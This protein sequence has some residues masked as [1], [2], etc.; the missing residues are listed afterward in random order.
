ML[1]RER[2]LIPL[3]IFLGLAVPLLVTSWYA[4]DLQRKSIVDLLEFSIDQK[5]DVLANGLKIPMWTLAP[6]AGS[7]LV[8]S[9]IDDPIIHSIEATSVAEGPFLSAKDETS[10]S[11]KDSQLV[12]RDVI[13][14]AEKIGEVAVLVDTGEITATSRA[15][16]QKMGIILTIQLLLSMGIVYLITRTY[17]KIERAQALSE[18]HE[19]V[20]D[21][22]ALLSSFMHHSP[23]KMHATD[24]ESRFIV[25]NTHYADLLGLPPS[26][27][28]GKTPYDVMSHDLAKP[29]VEHDQAVLQSGQPV[30][31]EQ[32]LNVNGEE[33][34]YL[35]VKFPLRNADGVITGIAGSGLDMTERKAAE[36]A[37]VQARNDL[38]NRVEERTHE[39]QMAKDNAESANRAKS[40]FLSTM[41]HEL[42]TP[43]NAIIGF[44]DTMA[45]EVYGKLGHPNYK[46]YISDI[47]VSGIHLLDLIND[48]LDVSAIEAGKLDLHNERVDMVDLIE[49]SIR[50]IRPRAEKKSIRLSWKTPDGAMEDIAN[51]PAT[52]MPSLANMQLHGDERRLVQILVNLLGNSVKFTPDKGEVWLA[53]ESDDDGAITIE[54]GDTG[55]GMSE[56]D[57][58]VAFERFGQVDSRVARQFE[59]TGLGLPLSKHL[60][61]LHDGVLGMHS[62]KGKGTQARISFP[63]HRVVWRE[64][65][66]A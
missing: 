43:L 17:G 26:E 53:V 41:S 20:R 64:T 56:D 55:I 6:S 47:S 42:R 28:I 45:T 25:V 38:E 65:G 51:G 39:L 31:R 58:G 19:K 22:E 9:A 44:A 29:L 7:S 36:K 2:H 62:E 21:S 8:L 23:G 15:Q 27:V 61:E 66:A 59:G 18:M 50:L 16:W 46:E 60:V 54:V 10:E 35:T 52:F 33:R 1:N 63:A 3:G 48:I 57:I 11:P 30:F 34:T 32:V 37:L 14:G 12:V 13:Y 49:K 4:L 5:I 40:E 24:L